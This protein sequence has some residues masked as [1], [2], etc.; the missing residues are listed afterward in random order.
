VNIKFASGKEI[1][2]PFGIIGLDQNGVVFGGYDNRI[3]DRSYQDYFDDAP[4]LSPDEQ[5]ELANL[6][7]ER[8][9]LFKK[10]AQAEKAQS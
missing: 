7:I 10:C 3:F 5:I 9:Q 6:M 2:P 8:W 1:A 4:E